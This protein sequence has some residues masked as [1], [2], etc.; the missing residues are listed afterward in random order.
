LI[1][2]HS[3]VEDGYEEWLGWITW[4]WS[5]LPVLD[6]F[7]LDGMWL[8]SFIFLVF[9]RFLIGNAQCD[10]G[11]TTWLFSDTFDRFIAAKFS[12]NWLISFLISST[13]VVSS[14]VIFLI[15]TGS[16]LRSHD[17]SL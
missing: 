12:G 9:D 17:E 4:D 2:S 5:K 7:T 8:I 16:I 6:R 13:T 10:A 11:G 14:V 1:I 15:G 3:W